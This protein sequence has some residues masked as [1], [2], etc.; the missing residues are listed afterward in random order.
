MNELLV[1]V[2]ICAFGGII[3]GLILAYFANKE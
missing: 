1:I 2:A 3:N